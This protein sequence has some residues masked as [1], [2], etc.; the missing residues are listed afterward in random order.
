MTG[1]SGRRNKRKQPSRR[2]PANW[3]PGRVQHLHDQ[4]K[5]LTKIYDETQQALTQQE[6][7]LVDRP[8]QLEV[9]EAGVAD[10]HEFICN[11]CWLKR[12]RLA[13]CGCRACPPSGGAERQLVESEIDVA[14]STRAAGAEG[15][16]SWLPAFDQRGGENE[17]LSAW[18]RSSSDDLLTPSSSGGSLASEGGRHATQHQ[19]LPNSVYE[20]PHPHN[21]NETSSS[22][23]PADDYG[24]HVPFYSGS[25]HVR[26]GDC[27]IAGQ[28]AAW[29][30]STEEHMERRIGEQ[31]EADDENG[32]LAHAGRFDGRQNQEGTEE[33]EVQRASGCNSPSSSRS[34]E[35]ESAMADY[36]SHVVTHPEARH[37]AR[38]MARLSWWQC[39]ALRRYGWEDL[40][41]ARMPD[42]QGQL[43]AHVTESREQRS[44]ACMAEI[45]RQHAERMAEISDRHAA[46]LVEISEWRAARL[47]QIS[48]Q[49]DAHMAEIQEG[50]AGPSRLRPALRW[51]GVYE[52][53]GEGGLRS[54]PEA[55]DDG[56]PGDTFSDFS[57]VHYWDEEDASSPA[58]P[59][60][61][62][63]DPGLFMKSSLR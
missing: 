48:E 11:V 47:A 55:E 53:D 8:Y 7:Q 41:A 58:G 20:P 62:D 33:I 36:I 37:L 12:P 27:S 9:R 6:E 25:P 1:Q 15:A 16:S 32:P 49:H 31:Y 5:H 39:L 35:D 43:A 17:L 60:A 28:R 4:A 45:E 13:R 63:S 2:R 44:D 29:A 34:S 26:H 46:R 40:Q 61:E 51:E 21:T 57:G 59:D 54:I 3:R 42:V 30:A 10:W 14:L 50:F 52:A 22:N 24:G 38:S 23:V 18:G 56:V 19:I